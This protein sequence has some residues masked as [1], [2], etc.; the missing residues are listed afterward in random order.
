MALGCWL[1]EEWLPFVLCFLIFLARFFVNSWR[2]IRFKSKKITAF[3]SF[4]CFLVN[5]KLK[6]KVEE[7]V[8]RG[9]KT[10]INFKHLCLLSWYFLWDF[11]GWILLNR[12]LRNKLLLIVKYSWWFA[13]YPDIIPFI[14]NIPII[15]DKSH[16]SRRCFRIYLV[17]CGVTS[18]RL[19]LSIFNLNSALPAWQPMPTISCISRKIW[20]KN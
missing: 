3:F 20:L 19:L 14:I 15:F 18:W 9:I 7:E 4:C 11:W 10:K 2:K 8:I 13:D 1:E 6:A 17:F 12:Y 5:I 16:L